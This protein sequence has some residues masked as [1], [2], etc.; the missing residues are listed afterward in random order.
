MTKKMKT[1]YRLNKDTKQLEEVVID[2]TLVIDE[3]GKSFED[4]VDDTHIHHTASDIQVLINTAIGI[5]KDEDDGSSLD[6]RHR[7]LKLISQD[8]SMLAMNFE[9][10][11]TG[12]TNNNVIDTIPEIRAA[13]ETLQAS[14][15]SLA[16][17]IANT[18]AAIASHEANTTTVHNI[19]DILDSIVLLQSSISTLSS[20]TATAMSELNAVIS[21]NTS[22]IATLNTTLDALGVTVSENAVTTASAIDAISAD[23]SDL[24]GRL[25][26]N[27]DGHSYLTTVVQELTTTVSTILPRST[28]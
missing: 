26:L 20:D 19:A 17:L 14:S 16:T 10:F 24:Q 12:T 8:L 6:D 15:S 1:L 9:T 22:T 25:A 21:G 27:E 23:I 28:A 7:S 4:H 3:T 18:A 11:R 13:L 2:S 5:L